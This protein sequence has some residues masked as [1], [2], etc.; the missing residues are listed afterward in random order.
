MGVGHRTFMITDECLEP[1]RAILGQRGII[2]DADDI[3]PWVHDW[4]GRYH[5][6]ARA[7]LSPVSTEEV[8]AVV[9]MAAEKNVPLVPQGGN[10]SMVGGATP[11]AD[12]SALILS[13]RRMNRIRSISPENRSEEHT[14][15]LQSLMRI[16]YAVFCL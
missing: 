12:G 4:R 13:L 7:I 9:A 2:E 15:E 16:S 14:S 5:G 11:P 10:T 3:D 8:A 6:Q 1:F